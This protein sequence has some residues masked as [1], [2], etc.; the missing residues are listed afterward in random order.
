MVEDKLPLMAPV[1]KAPTAG[2]VVAARVA[3]TLP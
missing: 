1:A 3:P 2:T